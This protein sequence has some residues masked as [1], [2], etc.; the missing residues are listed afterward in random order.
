MC[1]LYVYTHLVVVS[2]PQKPHTLFDEPIRLDREII[3]ST[4]PR[5]AEHQ[6]R[7]RVGSLSCLMWTE[8]IQECYR[9][10]QHLGQA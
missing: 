7:L 5:R 6:N 2:H 3:S 9:L 10:L 1:F 4:L 8:A